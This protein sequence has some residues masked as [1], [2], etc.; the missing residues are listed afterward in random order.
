MTSDAEKL[1][2]N[3]CYKLS[4]IARA[5]FGDVEITIDINR[6]EQ[7]DVEFMQEC[8][9]AVTFGPHRVR[10]MNKD[11]RLLINSKDELPF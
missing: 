8:N 1:L 11:F 6:V 2:A 5:L 10:I 7:K 9:N 3:E 4:E